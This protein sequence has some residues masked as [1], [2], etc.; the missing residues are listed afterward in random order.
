MQGC[1]ISL[2]E[3]LVHGMHDATLQVTTPTSR[4]LSQADEVIDK[5][6]NVRNRPQESLQGGA[7]I[8]LWQWLRAGSGAVGTQWVECGQRTMVVGAGW[9]PSESGGMVVSQWAEGG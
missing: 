9:F 1:R 6:I 2:G 7:V 3:H 4:A 5:H 8:R